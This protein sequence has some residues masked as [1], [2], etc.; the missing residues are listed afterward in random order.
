VYAEKM[1]TTKSNIDYTVIGEGKGKGHLSFPIA[2]QIIG[3]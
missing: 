3:T 1:A 2:M